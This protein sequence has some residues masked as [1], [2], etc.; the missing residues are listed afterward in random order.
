MS[1]E[2]VKAVA[3]R[4]KSY[5]TIGQVYELHRGDGYITQPDYVIDDEGQVSALPKEFM[6]SSHLY[7]GYW[8]ICDAGGEPMN[9]NPFAE[10]PIEGVKSDANRPIEPPREVPE[11]EQKAAED[12]GDKDRED[13]E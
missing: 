3:D 9:P 11:D 4:A 8:V 12:A 10:L 5:I 2:Y 1:Q 13:A 7:G 6:P